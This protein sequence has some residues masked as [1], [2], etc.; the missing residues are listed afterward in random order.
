MSKLEA[1]WIAAWSIVLIVGSIG[2]IKVPVGEEA[3][4]PRQ[5]QP[6]GDVGKDADGSPKGIPG[7]DSK[8]L[9]SVWVHID[10]EPVALYGCDYRRDLDE[11]LRSVAIR[12]ATSVKRWEI[13]PITGEDYSRPVKPPDVAVRIWDFQRQE[14][15]HPGGKTMPDGWSGF[16]PVKVTANIGSYAIE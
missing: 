4:R 8:R 2:P 1:V 5:P 10:G 14:W 9:F 13:D 7:H 3:P 6:I 15:H 11:L 12:F 16:L